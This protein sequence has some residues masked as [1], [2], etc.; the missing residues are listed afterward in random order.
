MAQ[1]AT[2]GEITGKLTYVTKKNTSV[3]DYQNR[4]YYAPEIL[5][6]NIASLKGDTYAYGVVGKLMQ[7]YC[8]YTAS[9][10]A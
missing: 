2:G 5:R 7:F 8:D 4:A 9:S 1:H 3:K 6:G 10:I